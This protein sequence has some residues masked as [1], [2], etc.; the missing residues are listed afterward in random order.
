MESGGAREC[1]VCNTSFA[2]NQSMR[3]HKKTVHEAIKSFQCD[4]CQKSFTQAWT[5]KAHRLTHSEKKPWKC[6]CGSAFVEKKFLKKH[7]KTRHGDGAFHCKYC[8][9][10][11][12]Y[13]HGLRKHVKRKHENKHSCEQ[14]GDS[15]K[16]GSDF[17]NHII[18][19]HEGTEASKKLIDLWDKS[20]GIAPAESDDEMKVLKENQMTNLDNGT[21]EDNSCTENVSFVGSISAEDSLANACEFE[22]NLTK[23]EDAEFQV[24]EYN[25]NSN[26]GDNT[27]NDNVDPNEEHKG[28]KP[29]DTKLMSFSMTLLSLQACQL[30]VKV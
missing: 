14:C 4:I 29:E 15:F 25:D 21:T 13:A 23:E 8:N 22:S 28:L 17:R 26:A 2:T 16:L 6:W 12:G 18:N 5:L 19:T 27:A 24:F 11:F 3:R 7:E 9:Q 30:H 1:P 10:E 20:L